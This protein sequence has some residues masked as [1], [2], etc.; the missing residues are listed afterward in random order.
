MT[1]IQSTAAA[2]PTTS[3]VAATG[4]AVGVVAATLTVLF[5]HGWGEA[6]SMVALIAAT[7]VVVYGMLVPRG[8][9]RGGA[10]NIALTLAV[11]AALVAVPAF[12]TGLPLVL[13]VAAVILGSAGRTARTGAGRSIGALV[14]GAL[15]SLFY[16][17]I[18]V[19]E[20]FAG[21]TG[22]LLS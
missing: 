20:A 22:F 3:R 16:L 8:L 15:A 17:S 18:Y 14:L 9:Q 4:A 11:I 7:T 2:H 19:M 21:N 10:P 5:A 1:T 6:L 12:W 13:G